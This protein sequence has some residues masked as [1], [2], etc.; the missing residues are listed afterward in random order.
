MKAKRPLYDMER[1][2][3]IVKEQVLSNDELRTAIRMVL[4][5]EQD[6]ADDAAK[7][8]FNIG[9]RADVAARKEA[10][11]VGMDEG[12]VESITALTDSEFIGERIALFQ[13]QLE[14]TQSE[15]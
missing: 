3:L 1:S 8:Q 13:N 14:E 7:D 15:S 6:L 11:A 10:H 4:D 5:Y 2:Y 12:F 9:D